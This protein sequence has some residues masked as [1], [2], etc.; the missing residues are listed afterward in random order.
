MNMQSMSEEMLLSIPGG[1]SV[2]RGIHDLRRQAITEDALLLL[3]ARQR[4]RALGLDLA[5]PT[6]TIEPFEHRLFEV[7][8]GRLGRGAHAAYNALLQRL[9][10]FLNAM[11]LLKRE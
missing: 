5:V 6:D 4:L 7:L 9:D 3:I 11:D 2:V 8:E 10:S 1:E